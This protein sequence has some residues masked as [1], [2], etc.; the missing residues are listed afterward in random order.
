LVVN[1]FKRKF[2]QRLWYWPS[3]CNLHCWCPLS[4]CPSF[5]IRTTPGQL[6]HCKRT[7]SN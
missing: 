6:G 3:S 4:Y 2:P 1:L 7:W 5:S